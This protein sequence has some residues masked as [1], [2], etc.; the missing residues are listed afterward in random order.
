MCTDMGMCVHAQVYKARYVVSLLI[1][2]CRMKVMRGAMLF[3][4]L[5]TMNAFQ[6][7]VHED[8]QLTDRNSSGLMVYIDLNGFSVA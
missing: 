4:S 3:L 6:V 5:C 2:L 7:L 8:L 1:S